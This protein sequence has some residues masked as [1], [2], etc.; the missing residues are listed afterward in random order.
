VNIEKERSMDNKALIFIKPDAAKPKVVDFVVKVLDGWGVC[1][2]EPVS[3]R[4]TTIAAE[5]TIDRHYFAIAGTA[6][7]RKPADYTLSEDAREAFRGSFGLRWEEALASGLLLNAQEAQ[8]R[9]GGIS[10]I[11][12]NELWKASRQVKMAPGLYAGFFADKGWYV[13]NGF[14][15]G[16]REV[17]T[18]PDAQV[19]LFEASFSPEKLHWEEF[20]S[21]VIGATDPTAAPES[22]LRGQI[23]TRYQELGIADRP[24]MSRNG[25]HASA[26]PVEGLRE[27]M[28]WLGRDPSIDP[29]S[30]KLIAEGLNPGELDR[31]LENAMVSVSGNRGPVFDLTEDLDSDEAVGRLRGV[32]FEG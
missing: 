31:L 12:L 9:L 1:L 2:S 16:Q 32:V 24:E 17:F 15:P 21:K 20:R 11:D 8:E 30:R 14:Y 5:R 18:N 26:G 3:V 10:G 25:V 22:S 28:V 6:V 23:L 19:I 29:L 13:I 4:G 27:R 7:E